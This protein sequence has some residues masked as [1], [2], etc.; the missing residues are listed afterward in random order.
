MGKVDGGASENVEKLSE[1]F[2]LKSNYQNILIEIRSNKRL[3]SFLLFVYRYLLYFVLLCFY[4]F[5]F[6]SLFWFEILNKKLWRHN[7]KL[8][9]NVFAAYIGDVAIIVGLLLSLFLL[10]PPLSLPLWFPDVVTL[11]P[12]NMRR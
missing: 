1:V 11:N 2:K 10:L 5:P 12:F 6:F 9:E 3:C 4:A 7:R 8:Y